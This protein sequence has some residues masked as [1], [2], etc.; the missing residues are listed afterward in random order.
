MKE[1]KGQSVLQGIAVGELFWYEKRG[2]SVN[3]E[4]SEDTAHEKHR[5][6][7]ARD[8]TK[9]Q[10]VHLSKRAREEAGAEEAAIFEGHMLMLE[11]V[12]Y[13][14][15]VYHVIE[16]R[17]GAEYAV[18]AAGEYF[19]GVFAK[20]DDAYMRARG[21][22]VADITHRML[23]ILTGRDSEV[24]DIESP[25]ILV[26]DNLTPSETVQMDRTKILGLVTRFGS[27]YSHTAILARA[28][29]IPA[30]VGVDVDASW[31]NREAVIDGYKGVVIVDPDEHMRKEAETAMKSMRGETE[32]LRQWKNEETITKSG[33]KIALFANIGDAEE[34]DMA[35]ENGAEGIGLFRSEILYL[36]A[37]DYPNEE[38]QFLAYKRV[39]ERMN[40]KK[41]VIRTLDAG[42]D[43]RADYFGLEGEENPA[44]GYR[45]IRLS[46]SKRKIFKT[47]LRAILRA[48]VFGRVS[49]MFPMIISVQEVRA[50]KDILEEAK[51]EL[52]EQ[53]VTYR[54]IEVGAMIETPAAAVLSEEIAGEVSFLSIGTND[55]TQ[56]ALAIDRQNPRLAEFYDPHHPAVLKMIRMTVENGHK[57]GA[58]VGICGE[59][60]ADTEL[61][62]TFLRMGV[63]ELSVSPR[64]ILPVRAKIRQLDIRN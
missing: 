64:Y 13:Q 51:C 44:M 33:K 25:V 10:L 2:L 30:L 14:A 46:L 27:P 41:V 60:A 4:E 57:A 9:Q 54:D 8:K 42:A 52:K 23:A 61:A 3:Y 62:E 38:E 47:Q 36:K 17:R 15:A 40:G 24:P 20:M 59:L 55:L 34:T 26:A 29:N 43:K 49:V 53:G 6:D 5:F 21:E 35:L 48:S 12:E 39:A 7:R 58:W 16:E 37:K 19:A 32:S 1:Y 28:M 63:D 50:A 18:A 11:D 31:H 22:D 56:Y 45:G